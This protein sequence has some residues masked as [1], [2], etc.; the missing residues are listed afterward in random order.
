[1]FPKWKIFAFHNK[2]VCYWQHLGSVLIKV[3]FFSQFDSTF[4]PGQ[5][6]AQA[7]FPIRICSPRLSG[8]KDRTQIG[9]VRLLTYV[10]APRKAHNGHPFCTDVASRCQGETRFQ[11]CCGL[12][13]RSQLRRH[14]NGPPGK[15]R[16]CS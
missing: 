12:C 5:V 14:A 2:R 8:K 11:T 13:D 16:Y 6:Q 9:S 15:F 3:R 7:A 10:L 4:A 1:M